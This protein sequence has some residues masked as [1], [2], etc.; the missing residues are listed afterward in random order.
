ME[1][2]ESKWLTIKVTSDEVLLIET[3][4]KKLSKIG[5]KASLSMILRKMLSIGTSNLDFNNLQ[6][7][8]LLLWDLKAVEA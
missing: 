7:S 1:N 4:K 5:I 3:L 8:P 2:N 6:K